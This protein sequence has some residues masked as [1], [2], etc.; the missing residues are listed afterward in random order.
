MN[1]TAFI[2]SLGFIFNVNAKPIYNSNEINKENLNINNSLRILSSTLN[3]NDSITDPSKIFSKSISTYKSEFSDYIDITALNVDDK[4]EVT[5]PEFDINYKA[6][7]FQDVM[8]KY[9]VNLESCLDSS[10]LLKYENFRKSDYSFDRY[11]TLNSTKYSNLNV[12]TKYNHINTVSLNDGIYG[13]NLILQNAGLSKVAIE[14]FIAAVTTLTSAISSSCI[15]VIGGGIAIALA[16][17]A[18][19]GLT[20]IIVQNWNNI[21]N[22]MEN[23]KNWFL[24]QFSKFAS[25]IRNY[26]ADATAKGDKSKVVGREK[27]G[28]IDVEWQKIIVRSLSDVTFLERCK[29]N[30]ELITLMRNVKK[31]NEGDKYYTSYWG[32]GGFIDKETLIKYNLYDKGISTYTKLES[33]AISL[34]KSGTIL[35]KY[36]MVNSYGFP[37]T[38]G[39]HTFKSEVHLESGFNHYHVFEYDNE[40]KEYKAI[41]KGTISKAHS[42]FGDVYFK[43]S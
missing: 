4:T 9:Q 27:I 19:I 1:F 33:T 11:V 13:L 15:P 24:N 18:L 5:L 38:T 10:H 21:Q 37:Y 32:W 28:D 25:L 31:F 12:S 26:F 16:T 34:L 36:N 14:A 29:D 22:S 7:S 6:P 42:F 8:Y 2:I 23:I 43:K 20:V 39:L 35:I 30:K 40:T 17:G 41:E 3:E